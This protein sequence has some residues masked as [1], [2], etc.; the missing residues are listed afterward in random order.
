[1]GWRWISIAAALAALVTLYS[2]LVDRQAAPRSGDDPSLS[3]GHYLKDAII[4]QTQA[5]GS[6]DLRLVAERIDQH[7]KDGS[8]R[9]DRVQM[10]YLKIPDR[11][12]VLTAEH[13]VIPENSRV[14]EF[15]GN[16]ELR[17]AQTRPQAYLHTEA[18]AIDTASNLA[19]TTQSPVSIRFG[20]YTM[21]VKRL[22]ADLAREKIRLQSARGQSGS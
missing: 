1:M 5:D 21:T 17:L 14:V 9:L 22:E 20:A 12:W 16:V 18:L 7:G 11:H 3:A 13:G 4:T 15:S 2:A 6:V 8:I 10:D 19:Y